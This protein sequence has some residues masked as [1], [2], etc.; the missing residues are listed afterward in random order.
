MVETCKKLMDRVGI[1]KIHYF[2]SFII[3]VHY[4]FTCFVYVNKFHRWL[5]SRQITF[6][7]L[8]IEE[9]K[10]TCFSP[11]TVFFK[12]IPELSLIFLFFYLKNPLD[13]LTKDHIKLP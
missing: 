13:T 4:T 1:K 6:N 2:S 8:I 7:T 12:N 9:F 5:Y 3:F 10:S 11:R